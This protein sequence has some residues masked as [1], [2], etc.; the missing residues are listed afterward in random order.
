MPPATTIGIPA[1]RAGRTASRELD[2]PRPRARGKFLER[3]GEKRYVRGVTY[4]GF[5][6][7]AAGEEFPER[8][9]VSADFAA[10]A[11]NGATTVRT[12]TCPP[13]WLLDEA[14]SHGLD[15][16]VGVAW[17]THVAVLDD[18]R[19]ADA[20][21][22]RVREA[23]R[24][25][26]GHPA[27]L[28]YAVGN[29]I[30]AG[31]VRWHGPRRVERFIERLAGAVREEDPAALVTYVNFPSTEYLELPF[32]DLVCFNVFLE[33]EVALRRYLAR[34][35]TLAG[36]RPLILTE[37]GLDS[38]R[39]GLAAQAESLRWQ[40][41]T[42]FRGGC[43]GVVVFSWTDE[44]HRGGADVLDW[45]FGLTTRERKPK[46]ALA[47]VREAF[48][49]APVAGARDLPLVSVVVC[50]HNGARTL[51]DCCE[52]LERLAY[53]RREVIVV[54]DGSTDDSAAIAAGYGF[55]V[56]STANGG[57]ASARNVGLEA[58]RGEIVAYIDDDAR[59]DPHWLDYLVH[60]LAESGSAGAG[61]PNLVPDDDALVAQCVA[62]APGNPRHVLIDDE[63]AE[64]LPGCNMAFRRDALLAIG[65]FDPQFRV[66]GDDVDVCWRL[67]DQGR[68][69]A[70]SPAA[71]VWHRR[72][73]SFRRFWR[74]QR[75]YGR[76]E[77]LLERKWPD[78]YNRVGHARWA[79]RLYGGA[80]SGVSR[81]RRTIDFGRHG[82][83]DFQSGTR[84]E[85][86]GIATLS[87]LPE[88]Y[89]AL[90][91][92][93]GAFA[94]AWL[95]GIALLGAPLLGVTVG[96]LLAGAA[97]GAA[98][99]AFPA[100]TRRGDL[101]RRRLLVFLLHLM[102]P[103]ARLVGRVRAGLTPW[104][105]FA[106]RPALPRPRAWALWSERWRPVAGWVDALA[107]ELRSRRV[108]VLHGGPTE[109]WELEARGGGLGGVRVRLALEEHGQGR[110]V[111]RLQSWP[112]ASRSMLALVAF[113]GVFGGCAAWYGNP[114]V[115]GILALLTIVFAAVCIRHC[116]TA[117]GALRDAVT[118]LAGTPST[119]RIQ[120]E[121]AAPAPARSAAAALGESGRHT[122]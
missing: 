79:G 1:R 75:E 61:G 97:V 37:V 51:A 7:N 25:C 18:A 38:R 55:R 65:G 77:A 50:T 73:D 58:A 13:E 71:V 19:R 106:S 101:V 117:A 86:L 9:T 59:P 53:P 108:A 87:G 103:L 95:C 43:A 93:A 44:W 82:T 12:Y 34:L 94:L 27:V 33:D 36:D 11:A 112:R 76:S 99:A 64:H 115:G 8:G 113:V 42:A 119:A 17:E 48:A 104:R 88:W 85:G 2:A 62:R 74:Q 15:V 30:P 20:V 109:R 84:R 110:Q 91:G 46:P 69:L 90:A 4:G 26:A 111:V 116:A 3:A 22:R 21:E 41:R 70:F 102:Q 80:G 54:D 40:V 66:A 57:L 16:M 83:G 63:R 68:E 96:V 67:L 35:Q 31:I 105:E 52:G 32:L 98:R 14:R 100:T 107:D 114:L 60:A 39:N 92:A 23:V 29:E 122:S 121:R 5:A 78:R 6:P 24:S 56:I 49:A 45:E 118:A 89:L 81:R 72:R 28:C 120:P 10:M 47:S